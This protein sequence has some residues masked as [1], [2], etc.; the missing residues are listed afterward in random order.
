MRKTFLALLTAALLICTPSF[1][2]VPVRVACI[3]DSITYGHGIEDR[4]RN[5]YP[6]VLQNLLGTS[7]DVR[8]FGFS[9]RVMVN[10]GD[11]PY[12]KETMYSEVK[13]FL[14]DVVMIMLGTNDTKPQNW[15]AAQYRQDY[16][17]MIREL[18]ALDSHPDIF[19]CYPPTVVTDRWGI[20]EQGVV[21]DVIPIIDDLASRE[22][23]DVI[24]THR[25]TRNMPQNYLDDG[26]HPNAGGA[27][28]LAATAADALRRNGYAANPGKRVLFIGDSITD[29]EWGGG[30]GRA[31]GDRS[32]YDMNHFLG[33][34]FPELCAARCMADR[35]EASFRFYNRGISG[36]TLY[37]L[38]KRWNSDALAVHPDIIS[39]LVGVN[40][41]S[42]TEDGAFDYG[43]W[44]ARYR[45]I[46][47]RTLA[48]DPD[49][50]IVLCSPFMTDKLLDGY[51]KE[52]IERHAV[53]ERLAAIVKEI[54]GDYGCTYVDTY[55]LVES[56]DASGKSPDHKYWS[57]DGVHPTT[58]CH[59]KI[60]DLWIRS[61]KKLL[62]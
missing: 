33:H 25:A 19:L 3:G 16:Q 1:A 41:S 48:F 4:E 42:H 11:H 29:G 45:S 40:D 39:I 23:L 58:A 14:P 57:W 30:R 18:K 6:A 27:A 36:N 54:A 52:Y 62:K 20:N 13:A 61:T 8:N 7:Y 22:W 56:L 44:E 12:M 46:M 50:R 31:S 26:V 17:T 24:D 51:S 34:G 9:A 15:N 37:D 47:D 28:V 55:S 32:H 38:S 59:Q 53:I 2:R 5:S 43:T 10:T 21:N 35:P 60:A 49:I